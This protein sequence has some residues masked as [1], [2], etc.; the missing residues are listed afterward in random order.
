MKTPAA[1]AVDSILK[2]I[3]ARDA[4]W[5]R[6]PAGERADR[7]SEAWTG[8]VAAATIEAVEAAEPRI[9]AEERARFVAWLRRR[10]DGILYSLSDIAE[11]IENRDDERKA[12]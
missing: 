1:K 11:A 9:R 2:W 8:I 3:K 6:L 7:T 12:G 5:I 10:D 4:E